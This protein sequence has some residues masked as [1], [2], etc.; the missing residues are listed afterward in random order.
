MRAMRRG[1]LYLIFYANAVGYAE[2]SL[3]SPICSSIIEYYKRLGHL[4]SKDLIKM[5]GSLIKPASSNKEL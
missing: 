5:V 3:V 1:D 2:V 4:N